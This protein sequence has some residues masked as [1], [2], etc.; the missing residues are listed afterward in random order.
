MSV[1]QVEKVNVCSQGRSNK[2]KENY[3]QNCIPPSVGFDCH[4]ST[5]LPMVSANT[6]SFLAYER[7]Q[8][9]SPSIGLGVVCV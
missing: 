7:T 2:V 9:W 4:E 8:V 1:T 6:S 3:T 5:E